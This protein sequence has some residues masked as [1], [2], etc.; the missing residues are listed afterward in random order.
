MF[1]T[2]IGKQTSNSISTFIFKDPDERERC[3]ILFLENILNLL[4]KED[5][6]SNLAQGIILYI[7]NSLSDILKISKLTVDCLK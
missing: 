5:H 6:T 1:K 7:K 4:L 3:I 2:A